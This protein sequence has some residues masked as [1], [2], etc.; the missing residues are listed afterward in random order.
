MNASARRPVALSPLHH[1]HVEL[2]AEMEPVDGW[3]RPAR[4]G[5]TD[6][7]LA[8]V[9]SAVGVCD[10]SPM[11]KLSLQGNGLDALL[12][13]AFPDAAPPA[14][15]QA[16]RVVD[17]TVV[18][19]LAG[20]EALVTTT[21][22]RPERLGESAAGGVDGCAHVVDVTSAL[23]AVRVVGAANAPNLLAALTEL[24][25]STGRVPRHLLHAVAVRGDTRHAG[26]A[27]RGGAAR[28]HAPVR[29]RV[30]RLHV[31]VD[32]GGGRALRPRALRDSKPWAG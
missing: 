25:V 6:E 19:R 11:G 7:E 29:P 31:G 13:S 8:A 20:D 16:V 10:V 22:G 3:L 5:D 18:A 17:E 4:Y 12:G 24:D 2:G 28:L 30:R 32:H 23:A 1:V 15:G 9:R 14:V 27:Q 21:T 26:A